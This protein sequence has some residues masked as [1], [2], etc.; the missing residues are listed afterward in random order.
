MIEQIKYVKIEVPVRYEEEDIPNDYPM[1]SNDMWRITVEAD[2]GIILNWPSDIP[3][4]DLYMKVTDMG[5][6]SVLDKNQNELAIIE[7]DYVPD[8]HSIPGSYGDYI[9]FKIDENGRITNWY[10]NPTYEEF[11]NSDEDEY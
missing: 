5:V 2:T 11:F 10:E 1:R 9:D 3:A 7:E 6:Y 4:K 8:S